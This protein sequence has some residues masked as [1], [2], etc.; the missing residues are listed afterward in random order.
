MIVDSDGR[1]VRALMDVGLYLFPS[2]SQPGQ[3][4]GWRVMVEDLNSGVQ[5][6]G[7][8]GNLLSMAQDKNNIYVNYFKAIRK[9]DGLICRYINDD[10]DRT[11]V[12]QLKVMQSLFITGPVSINDRNGALYF[13]Y[14]D[15]TGATSISD[16]VDHIAVTETSF[17]A[18]CPQWESR[19]FDFY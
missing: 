3:K 15:Q 19:E 18:G 10:F 16:I 1:G 4:Q 13:I 11:N 8:D 5:T 9:S 17:V 2:Y 14:S 6:A 7:Y 12:E